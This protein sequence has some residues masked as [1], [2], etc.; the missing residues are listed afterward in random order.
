ML[1]ASFSLNQNMDLLS[2]AIKDGIAPAIV[3]A[4]YLIITKIIESKDKNAQ[5]KLSSDLI[6]SI[7]L[8]SNYIVNISQNI[9]E[10]DK[11]KC[12]VAIEDAMYASGMKLINF[13]STTL[14]SNHIIENKDN[15]LANIHNLVN[16]EYYNIYSTLSLYIIDG[17]K[18]SEYLNKDW[19][20][21]IEED[22]INII[23]NTNLQKE[24]KILTFTNKINIKIQSYIT[25]II[26]NAI[27]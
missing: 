27:K 26:N 21:S 20:S 12:K 11:T 14:V 7:N 9:I 3:V 2:D 18:V 24:D 1:I 19:I 13:V 4:I 8:I 25:F 23:Y 16:A 5:A 17:A 15:I 10:K 6:K 22:M